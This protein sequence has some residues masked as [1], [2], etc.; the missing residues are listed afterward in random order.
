MCL[1]V[2]SCAVWGKKADLLI[3][4][5]THL[6]LRVPC[7]SSGLNYI[8]IPK[9][10]RKLHYMWKKLHRENSSYPSGCCYNDICIQCCN[11]VILWAF[12]MCQTQDQALLAHLVTLRA[13]PP[14]DQEGPV[15]RM[16]TLP[17]ESVTCPRSFHWQG[18][19]QGQRGCQS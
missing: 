5:P 1:C 11:N 8:L 13:P 18:Q 17:W 9:R 16:R 6:L 10:G 14:G 4:H 3:A 2:V 12:I 19:N 15:S 7:F